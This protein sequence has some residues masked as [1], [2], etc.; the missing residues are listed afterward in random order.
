MRCENENEDAQSG[1]PVY[2][3]SCYRWGG[4]RSVNHTLQG[5]E[6]TITGNMY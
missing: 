6:D 3:H 1:N 2:M 4:V 5:R